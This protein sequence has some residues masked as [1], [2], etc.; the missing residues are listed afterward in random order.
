MSIS[1]TVS[2]GGNIYPSAGLGLT[3]FSSRFAPLNCYVPRYS[4]GKQSRTG[5]QDRRIISAAGSCGN[6]PRTASSAADELY[7]E[8]GPAAAVSGSRRQYQSAG[9][10]RQTDRQTDYCE[11]TSGAVAADLIF[12]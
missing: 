4:P 5:G 3:S 10:G 2:G 9:T 1:G 7:P 8:P 12:G 6:I 11:K